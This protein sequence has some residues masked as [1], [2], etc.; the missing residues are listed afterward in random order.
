M[1]KK[2]NDKTHEVN[3][4]VKLPKCYRIK[5][6]MGFNSVC[7]TIETKT[8]TKL[9]QVV[10]NGAA[11]QRRPK[12]CAVKQMDLGPFTQ[13]IR[14]NQSA[15]KMRRIPLNF[16]LMNIQNIRSVDNSCLNGARFV[17]QNNAKGCA[18]KVVFTFWPLQKSNQNEAILMHR[19]DASQ[20][21]IWT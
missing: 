19:C 5:V 17:W 11:R 12:Q 1:K 14:T 2:T 16:I 6:G 9:D 8:L 15:N 13:F 3:W 7:K 21:S 18:T 10:E 20:R 4:L